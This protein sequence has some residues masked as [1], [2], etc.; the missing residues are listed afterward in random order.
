VVL[1]RLIAFFTNVFYYQSFGVPEHLISPADNNLGWLAIFVP[2]VGGLIIGLMA[3]YGSERIRG[4]RI[5]EALQAVLIRPRPMQPKVAVIKPLSSALSIGSGGPFGAEGPIIMT[6]GAVGSIIAQVFQMTAAERKTLLVAGAAGGMAATFGTPI[7]AV[8]LAVELLLFA[9]KTRSPFPVAVACALAMTVRP[10]LR[11]EG[12][13]LFDV[14]LHDPLDMLG[15]G[16]AAVVGVLAGVFALLLTLAVYTWEDL[17]HRLPFHWMWWPALGGLAIGIGGYFQPR[18][19]GVGYDII[20]DLLRASSRS[21]F[22]FR[23]SSSRVS[24]GRARSARAPPAVC[25][26]R[27]SS[28]AAPW[29]P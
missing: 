17:F 22:S 23:S 24:S 4:P 15:M 5:P 27:C 20:Q 21:A 28:W 13:P 16:S 19:L 10:L 9:W 12:P 29:D 2:V 1:Q 14:P 11:L 8:L 26:H 7:A 6:G 18:A 25:W 3:R